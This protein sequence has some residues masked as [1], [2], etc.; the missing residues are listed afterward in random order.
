MERAAPGEQ[1][2]RVERSYGRFQRKLALP[3]GVDRDSASASFRDGVLVVT[4]RKAADD[5]SRPIKLEIR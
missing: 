3:A 1:Y 5:R 2:H 4:L